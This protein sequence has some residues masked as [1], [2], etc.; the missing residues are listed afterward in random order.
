MRKPFPISAPNRAWYE[1]HDNALPIFSPAKKNLIS[2]SDEIYPPRNIFPF[3][4][5]PSL[6]QLFIRL[7]FPGKNFYVGEKKGEFYLFERLNA[8]RR[9]GILYIYR[10]NTPMEYISF[11]KSLKG[12]AYKA[13]DP[14]LS[15]I[16]ERKFVFWDHGLGFSAGDFCGL[17]IYFSLWFVWAERDA[18]CLEYFRYLVRGFCV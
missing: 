18:M 3:F 8:R 5:T 14:L 4:S 1:S 6:G 17:W 2:L 15:K 13:L 10:R 12:R 7:I 11:G 9:E 16:L